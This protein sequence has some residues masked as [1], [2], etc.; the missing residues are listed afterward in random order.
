MRVLARFRHIM[1]Y[2]YSI[3]NVDDWITSLYQRAGFLF[4]TPFA[5]ITMALLA[6]LGFF[7]F[8]AFLPHAG[9]ILKTSTHPWLLLIL[10][11]PANL[12]AV[13][14]HE[15]AH[16][17]TTKA[18]GYQVH[19]FGFGWLWFG[20]IAFAD[21]SDMWLSS[22]GPR[23]AVNLSGIYVNI[24]FSGLLVLIA[25]CLPY[26]TVAVF[27]WLMA[28]S[29]YLMAFYNLDPMFELDGY[30]V[31]MDALEKPN[32]RTHAIRWLLEDSKKSLRSVTL[33]YHYLPELLYWVTSILFILLATCVA[34]VIQKFV[35]NNILPG[36]IGH[37]HP[38]HYNWVLSSLVFLLSFA[39]LYSKVKEQAY[40]P[41]ARK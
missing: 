21:T 10:V 13:P 6:V 18:Y 39:S 37:H 25:W 34:Y 40:Q 4:F 14:L 20:P 30:Y 5:K 19:R 15:L 35:F 1:Q 31:L 3:N 29:S 26:P 32:L 11:G 24:V 27:L 36:S 8:A 23:I 28:L 33:L 17:L 12:L 9:E 2:E 22:R 7:A 41:L 38:S 16:A